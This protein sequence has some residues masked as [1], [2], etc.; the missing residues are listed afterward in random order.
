MPM[1]QISIER[2]T[3]EK[4]GEALQKGIRYNTSLNVTKISEN[5]EE[6]KGL[7]EFRLTVVTTP[8]AISFMITGKVR[9]QANNNE[10]KDF[11]EKPEKERMGIIANMILPHLLGTL[12]LMSRE[13]QVPPPIPIIPLQKNNETKKH[14]FQAI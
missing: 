6:G 14:E 12:V 1:V 9:I 7:Y 4:I 10:K 13:L 3:A 11:F 8:V 5:K 2:I